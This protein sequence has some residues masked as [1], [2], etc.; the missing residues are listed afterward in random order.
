M[1][2]DKD[3]PV[4]HSAWAWVQREYDRDTFDDAARDA[5]SEWLNADPTHRVVYAKA[6]RLWLL[7][8][9]VPPVNDLGDE[10]RLR[11]ADP[12]P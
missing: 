2:Y 10:E 11:D 6:A 8:G 3:D 9:L 4:W 7:A 5:L 1:T 12:Q